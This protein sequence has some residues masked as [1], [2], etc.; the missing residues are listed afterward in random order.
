MKKY[1]VH[2]TILTLLLTVVAL[3][4]ILTSTASFTWLLPIAVIYYACVTSIGHAFVT[5]SME[6]DPRTFVTR[7]LG[8]SVGTMM[9]HLTFVVV[10]SVYHMATKQI[11]GTKE[12]LVA[13]SILFLI[14]L[15]FET[16]E[17]VLH[18]KIEKKKHQ[19]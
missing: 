18:V 4:L 17:L 5:H 1:F 10:Y 8:A 2:I 9:L 16:I 15:A 11:G 3:V 6:K 7:F 14:Y 13:F 12:F 19:N